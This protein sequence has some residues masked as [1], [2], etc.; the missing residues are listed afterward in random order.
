MTPSLLR[1]KTYVPAVRAKVVSRPRLI[2]RLN[3]GRKLTLVSAPAG[4][5][6]TTLVGEWLRQREHPAAWLSLDKDDNDPV[7]FWQYVVAALQTVDDSIGRAA[8][9]ALQSPQPPAL[10]ALVTALI[11]DLAVTPRPLILV[12]DDYHVIETKAIHDS[13]DF[14]LDHLPPQL[15]LVITTRA[16]PP[17]SLSRRRGRSELVEVRMAHL[18]FTSEEAAEFLNACMGL[19]ISAEDVAVLDNRVEGWIVGLQMAALAMKAP[20]LQEGD[21]SSRHEFVLAF[22]GD[23]RHVADYLMEEVLQRQP[24]HLQTFLLQT[25]ILERLCGPL[26]DAVTGREDGQDT[27]AALE[28]SNLFIVPLDNRRQWYRY[29]A[30]FADLLRWRLR[31]SS[32]ARKGEGEGIEALHLRASCWYER[33]S[34]IAEAVSHALAASD[35]ERTADLIEEHVLAA[36]LRSE[37]PL[38]HSWLKALPK[39]LLRTRPMLCAFYA[40]ST[41]LAPP[42]GAEAAKL[43]DEWLQEAEKGLAAPAGDMDQATRD[44]LAV[45]VAVFRAYQARIRGDE[46]QTVVE[47]SSRALELLPEDSLPIRS[48]LVFNLGVA[49]QAL[50]QDETAEETLVEARQLAEACGN[51]YIACLATRFQAVIVR[52]H[53]R[54]HEAA[55]LCRETIQAIGGSGQEER[56]FPVLGVVYVTLGEI[57]LEWNDLEE[58]DRALAKGLELNA[59]TSE[60]HL[61]MLGYFAL[62]RVKQAQGDLG[63]AFAV[64][65]RARALSPR[66]APW[67]A[68]VQA[69]LQLAQ[70]EDDPRRLAAVSRWLQERGVDL[71]STAF[72]WRRSAYDEKLV[73]VR[74][75]IAQRRAHQ[76]ASGRSA[77]GPPN[78][79]PVLRF[80]DAQRQLVEEGDRVEWNICISVLQ[81]L[82]WQALG[83]TPSALDALERA[84]ALAEPGGYVRTFLDGGTAMAALLRQTKAQKAM[85]GYVGRLLAAFGEMVPGEPT[86]PGAALLI[87]PLTPRENEVLQLLAAG[88][89]NAQIAEELFITVNTVKRHITHILGKLGVENRTQ[90]AMRA[91][92]LG[93]ISES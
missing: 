22:A 47:L 14:L 46:P 23:D 79:Q 19:D 75:L 45:Y 39:D 74:L 61:Q 3:A 40:L 77:G 81:A 88:A 20:L 42:Y 57:L 87:E 91:R 82:A 29:H 15:R 64:L 16:D 55:A 86:H 10:E 33:E 11:N 43:A 89:S 38:V 26:C 4:F 18:R 1:T 30:L 7:R 78:L 13:L 27:L 93:L 49:Y 34:F 44:M 6:K 83:N 2:E 24:A 65:E 41:L 68:C 71:E 84:L 80:L 52:K 25:S 66:A 36:L 70:A 54:L 72:H 92:E 51:Y 50:D 60:W 73:L 28:Q 5:G 48:A 76:S 37:V 12:L 17:F 59:L 31:Q 90:A 67:V 69:A 85:P 9:A 62:S 8:Q 32:P 58:A 35:F 53:G 56:H 63:K 21:A